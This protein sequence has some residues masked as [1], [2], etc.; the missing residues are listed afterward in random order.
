M[1]EEEKK[2]L[3]PDGKIEYGFVSGCILDCGGT[4]LLDIN[5]QSNGALFSQRRIVH[6]DLDETIMI[7]HL[8]DYAI[9]PISEYNDLRDKIAK[10]VSY[11]PHVDHNKVYG[12]TRE[13]VEGS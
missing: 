6:E 11:F 4:S 1:N 12:I 10:W 7:P 13:D 9:I 8:K 3:R 5:G 2:Q